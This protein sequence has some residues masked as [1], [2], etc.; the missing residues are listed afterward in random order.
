MLDYH[1]HST[2][3]GDGK[4]TIDEMCSRAVELGIREIAFTEHVVYNPADICYRTFD[5]DLYRS[6]IEAARDKFGGLRILT[7]TEFCDPHVYPV[8]L[9][10]AQSWGLDMILGSVHWVGD[11]MIS[12]DS[13]TGL[14]VMETYH[15]YFDEVLKA[16]QTGGFDVLAHFDLVKR[17]GVRHLPFSVEPLRKQIKAILEVMI[18]R[19]IALELNTSG[20]RQPCA[21]TFP[22]RETLELYRSLGG[23]LVTIGSDSHRTEQ[24]GFGLKEGMALLQS[25][26]LGRIRSFVH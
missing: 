11:A 7:G 5:L 22:G 21:E 4:A 19:G 14:D 25:V 12:V 20:L 10:E 23:E 16:V 6:R 15:Q 2:C 1:V 18:G 26:G 13:F 8:Q 24:L 3:S 9:G 17:F